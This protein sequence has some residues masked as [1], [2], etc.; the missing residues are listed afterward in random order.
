MRSNQMQDASDALVRCGRLFCWRLARIVE[1]A[2]ARTTG[3]GRRAFAARRS[4][5]L[6][7]SARP[8]S[9]WA[10]R[11]PCCFAA[12][13]T[14]AIRW[15]RAPRRAP[16]FALVLF[17]SLELKIQ[18]CSPLAHMHMHI[19]TS[20]TLCILAFKIDYVLH[21]LRSNSINNQIM[22]TACIF[23]CLRSHILMQSFKNMQIYLQLT[24]TFRAQQCI[25][26]D[27]LVLRLW[28]Q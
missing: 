6:K 24:D 26:I 5:R 19:H 8:G 11:A 3:T 27:S 2:Y 20:I 1:N 18:H 28:T 17:N 12:V 22:S 9:G 25:C 15:S 21:K 16:C 7:S 14:H 10:A 13:R 23:G 4:T